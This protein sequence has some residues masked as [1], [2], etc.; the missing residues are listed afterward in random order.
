MLNNKFNEIVILDVK[1]ESNKL[2]FLF[3]ASLNKNLFLQKIKLA[4]VLKY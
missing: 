2:L 1:I 3:L 4:T